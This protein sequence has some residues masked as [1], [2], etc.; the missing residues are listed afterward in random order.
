MIK[1]KLWYEE[2]GIKKR[3]DEPKDLFTLIIKQF[4]LNGKL[5]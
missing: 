1:T 3:K 2:L 5:F 4:G